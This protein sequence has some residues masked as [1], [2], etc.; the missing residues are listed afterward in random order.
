MN[1]DLNSTTEKIIGA[2]YKVSNTLGCGFVE[3][4][5]ENSLALELSR[6]KYRISQQERL[7]VYYDGLLVGEFFADLIVNHLILLEI[8]SVAAISKNHEAQCLNYLK[9]SKLKLGLV[10]NFGSPAVQIKRLINRL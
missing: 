5:Y 2:A 6:L 8:K 3:R 4:V 1:T 7:C 10:I 9:A